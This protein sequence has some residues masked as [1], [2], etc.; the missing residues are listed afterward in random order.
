MSTLNQ[1][2]QVSVAMKIQMSIVLSI[3]NINT[4]IKKEKNY[5]SLESKKRYLKRLGVQFIT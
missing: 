1:N 5:N 4:I 2:T 3:A